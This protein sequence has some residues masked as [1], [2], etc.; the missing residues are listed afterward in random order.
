VC[1]IEKPLLE[2]S[3]SGIYHRKKCKICESIR[4][5]AWDLANRPLTV[6]R[7]KQLDE[8]KRA[9]RRRGMAYQYLP[10]TFVRGTRCW[11]CRR[12]ATKGM[13]CYKCH[14]GRSR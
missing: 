6:E 2:F 12:E 13:L 8:M 14:N 10:I 1:G 9:K 7:R 4:K 3:T 11:C 5:R